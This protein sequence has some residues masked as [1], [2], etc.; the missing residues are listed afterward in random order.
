METTSGAVQLV[1]SHGEVQ[2]SADPAVMYDSAV[3]STTGL[4]SNQEQLPT[5]VVK[6]ASGDFN[7][8]VSVDRSYLNDPSTVF[9]VTIDPTPSLAVTT[10][11]YVDSAHPTG[12]FQN[13]T[14]LP[15]GLADTGQVQRPLLLFPLTGITG[16]V[17]SATLNLYETRSGSC[18][19][20]QVDIYNVVGAWGGTVK[21]N[22]QPEVGDVYASADTGIGYGSACPEGPVSF[23]TGGTGGET[24]TNLAQGWVSG[25]IINDGIEIRADDETSTTAYKRFNSSDMGSNPPSL[26]LTYTASIVPDPPSFVYAPADGISP[27][28][29]PLL[30]AGYSDSAGA[31]GATVF[32]VYNQNADG[33]NGTVV[34]G[35]NGVSG[36]TVASGGI[37]TY[38]VPSGLLTAGSAYN[39]VAV[40]S[41]GTNSSAPAT[42]SFSVDAS[43][44]GTTATAMSGTITDPDG[45]AAGNAT[46]TLYLNEDP[47]SS[48]A[49]PVVGSARTDANGNY[50]VSANLDDPNVQAEEA[51]DGGDVTFDAV[52]TDA[53]G[54]AETI[55]V[56]R[57][58]DSTGTSWVS[59]DPEN[60]SVTQ[61]VQIDTSTPATQDSTAVAPLA[62]QVIPQICLKVAVGSQWLTWNAIGEMHTGP[63]STGTTTYGKQVNTSMGF[64][65]NSGGS[66]ASGGRKSFSHT[67]SSSTP[68]SDGGNHSDIIQAQMNYQRYNWSCHG[69]TAEPVAWHGNIRVGPATNNVDCSSQNAL[70]KVYYDTNSSQLKTNGN[71]YVEG[72]QLS[73]APLSGMLGVNLTESS[74][75]ATT[76]TQKWTTTSGKHWLCWPHTWTSFGA[77][78]VIWGASNT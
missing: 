74:T 24:L 66:W 61:N 4:P 25:A 16:T 41:D 45:G 44:G 5:N 30:Q 11:T 60:P 15:S 9:P 18:T 3:S 54:F 78:G 34:T 75:F 28:T 1:N 19:P 2:A 73:A 7:L 22:T 63:N 77:A 52:V 71:S 33:T 6:T 50:S 68:V 46:V 48:A 67:S 59:D 69:P 47:D 51:A 27:N 53:N 43:A 13:N 64:E 65:I 76:L 17:Q 12:T 55:S 57:M 29:T 38:Q 8:E 62:A 49:L 39:V 72:F 23:S 70:Y 40:N 58:P 35:L 32:T 26:S 37:S 56:V 14:L 21:W 36:S 20:T 10:D 42:T 31:Q